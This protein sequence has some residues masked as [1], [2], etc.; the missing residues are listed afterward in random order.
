MKKTTRFS[1]AGRTLSGICALGTALATG[2]AIAADKE[3]P[4]QIEKIV[5]TADRDKSFGTD[6]VQAGTF[7]NARQIDT[8]LTVSVISEFVLKAQQ[9]NGILDALRNS[10][11]VTSSQI[12]TSVYSNLAI[13]GIIVEN[14]G[15]FRLNGTLPIINLID[16][17]LEN[18]YRVEALK[19]SSALYY[20]FTT[21]AG[22]INL[23]SKRP[24]S[25]PYFGAKIAGNN[26]GQLVGSVDASNTWGTVGARV[27]GAFGSQDTGVNKVEGDRRF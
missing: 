26:Y 25:E 1:Q 20:G 9:A 8:P 27:N 11:G 24:T 12:N 2:A 7:R 13:R 5:I 21:P 22:I 14:R 3:E 4:A 18:K 15:N 10:A 6:Y 17:P 16:M 19:G 23:T